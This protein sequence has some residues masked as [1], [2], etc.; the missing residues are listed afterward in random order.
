MKVK[1]EVEID[2]DSQTD[3][4]IVIQLIEALKN[5]NNMYEEDEE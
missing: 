5:L 2:T 4:D 1:L 3:S